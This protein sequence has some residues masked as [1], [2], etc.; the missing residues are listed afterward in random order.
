M[1]YKLACESL[2][3]KKSNK[4]ICM[5]E[6]MR[7]WSRPDPR[8]CSATTSRSQAPVLRSHSLTVP[9]SELDR[10][11]PL[12]NCRH[13][14]ADWCLLEP[15]GNVIIITLWPLTSSPRQVLCHT[16]AFTHSLH[17]VFI[18]FCCMF[19]FF[20]T[21]VG[22]LVNA[23]SSAPLNCNIWSTRWF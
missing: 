6:Y 9:S 8:L 18:F 5:W 7:W 23:V 21:Q 3:E 17:H 14:T 4:I 19:I 16:N 10:T 22:L 20:S 11:R 15:E 2:M 1:Q 13:V 12:Q